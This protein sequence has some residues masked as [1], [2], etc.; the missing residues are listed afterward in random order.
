MYL[1]VRKRCEQPIFEFS[2]VGLGFPIR[3]EEIHDLNYT[4][5]FSKYRLDKR[6]DFLVPISICRIPPTGWNGLEFPKLFPTLGSFKDFKSSKDEKSFSLRYKEEV[7][8]KFD[9]V[10]I[11]MELKK[12]SGFRPFV[13]LCYEKRG[14]FCHRNLIVNWMQEKKL[15]ITEWER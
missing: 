14:S 10:Q 4:S 12:I 1:S 3:K 15:P 11:F 13:L 5:Y 6:M 9:P 7:L 2:E 8:D